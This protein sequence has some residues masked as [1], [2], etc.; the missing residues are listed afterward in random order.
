MAS[1]A[2]HNCIVALGHLLAAKIGPSRE[3][4][5]AVKEAEMILHGSQSV[6]A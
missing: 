6:I 1:A 3:M 2:M 4:K 5:V